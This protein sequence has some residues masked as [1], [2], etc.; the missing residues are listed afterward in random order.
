VAYESTRKVSGWN[1]SRE[2]PRQTSIEGSQFRRGAMDSASH[3]RIR[4]MQSMLRRAVMPVLPRATNSY[5]SAVLLRT[6]HVAFNDTKHN[7]NYRRFYWRNSEKILI[8]GY[9]GDA[10]SQK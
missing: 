6:H 5:L 8:A 2:L 7:T 1:I 9:Q 4:S 10:K 3:P